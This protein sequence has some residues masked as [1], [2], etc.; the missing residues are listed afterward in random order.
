MAHQREGEQEG[1]EF[2]DQ[3][4]SAFGEAFNN[5]ASMATPDASPRM[6]TSR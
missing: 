1:D 4:V 6:S 5:V 3:V 2:E